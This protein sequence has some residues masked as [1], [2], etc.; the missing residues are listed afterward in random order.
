M[1]S[2]VTTSQFLEHHEAPGSIIVGPMGENAKYDHDG[3]WRSFIGPAV[4]FGL[5]AT[6]SIVAALSGGSSIRWLF[7]V[8]AAAVSAT[9]GVIAIRLFR[10]EVARRGTD[11]TAKPQTLP[12]V[13]SERDWLDRVAPISNGAY[14]ESGGGLILF[15]VIAVA[16]GT[17]MLIAL[18]FWRQLRPMPAGPLG[19][20]CLLAGVHFLLLA[21]NVF[22]RTPK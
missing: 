6:G 10:R 14:R 13:A 2:T 4:V 17:W 20:L 18:P 15:G 21:V 9:L 11:D 19:I 8:I 1:T 3:A 7:A 16:G 5:I 12:G 22:R